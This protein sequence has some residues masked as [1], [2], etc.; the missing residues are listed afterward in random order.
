MTGFALQEGDTRRV[1]VVLDADF[2]GSLLWA[3]TILRG[4]C[5]A[6][7]GAGSAVAPPEVQ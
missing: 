4:N 5:A 1:G 3:R 2:P 6:P 7:G